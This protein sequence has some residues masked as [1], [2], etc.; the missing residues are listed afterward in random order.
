MKSQKGITLTSLAIYI[1]LIFIVLGILATVTAN[2]QK[3]INDSNKSGAEIAEI[4][5]FNMYFLQEVKRK[6]NEILSIDENQITF[7]NGKV[8]TFIDNSIKFIDDQNTII[9]CKNI[10]NCQFSCNVINEKKIV[11]VVIKIQNVDNT[12]TQE[13]VLNDEDLLENYEN[14]QYYVSTNN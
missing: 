9:I 7:T 8:F 5:K 10:E 14:E 4:N 3:G 2:M 12:I 6:G 11:T 13:F 1:V